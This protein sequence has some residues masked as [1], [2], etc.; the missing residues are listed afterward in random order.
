MPVLCG[1]CTL[2]TV[3]GANR[4]TYLCRLPVSH[5]CVA[6]GVAAAAVLAASWIRRA[7]R[8][9][10]A[11]KPDATTASESD[12]GH[13]SP[14]CSALN[15][16]LPSL[17]GAMLC[18]SNS[19]ASTHKLGSEP[20]RE[21]PPPMQLVCTEASSRASPFAEPTPSAP[22][23]ALFCI[24]QKPFIPRLNLP[25][26]KPSPTTSSTDQHP[27]PSLD[28]PLGAPSSITYYDVARA[29][30]TLLPGHSAH[31]MRIYLSSLPL[32]SKPEALATLQALPASAH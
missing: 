17:P 31:A 24:P 7:F 19:A 16:V 14:S 13:P 27:N 30:R 8:N 21:P 4:L 12:A 6:I 22:V 23:P 3:S 25:L 11:K 9:R 5:R 10:H 29:L 28:P 1:P 32:S 26:R 2:S 20:C 15:T 18:I